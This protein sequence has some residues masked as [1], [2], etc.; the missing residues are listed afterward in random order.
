MLMNKPNG[1]KERIDRLLISR[2]RF[3][4]EM[5]VY[6]E[7]DHFGKRTVNFVVNIRESHNVL[8]KKQTKKSRD[9]STK[10]LS[11]FY[12]I[13]RENRTFGHFSVRIARLMTF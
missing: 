12:L 7:L 8:D 1:M 9:V 5:S 6:L 13:C 3:R 11:F 2:I 10:W 4:G